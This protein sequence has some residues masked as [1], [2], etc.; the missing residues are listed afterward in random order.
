M[1]PC[2]AF[3][4]WRFMAGSSSFVTVGHPSMMFRMS[5][6]RRP[7]D[8]DTDAGGGGGGDVGRAQAFLLGGAGIAIVR[9]PLLRTSPDEGV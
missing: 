9:F 3:A 4:L 6:R 7:I 2:R 5:L 1:R 8:L